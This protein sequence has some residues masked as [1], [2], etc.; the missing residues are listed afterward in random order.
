MTSGGL[1]GYYDVFGELQERC[2]VGLGR[3]VRNAE[4][5]N[6]YKYDCNEICK[7]RKN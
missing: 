3:E 1:M 5:D 2:F 4:N 7:H 6:Q